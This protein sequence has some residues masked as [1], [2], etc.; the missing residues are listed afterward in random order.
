MWLFN[1][2]SAPKSGQADVSEPIIFRFHQRSRIANALKFLIPINLLLFVSIYYLYAHTSRLSP[3]PDVLP[4][5]QRLSAKDIFIQ[6]ALG[7]EIDGPFNSAPLTAL[8]RQAQWIDGLIIKCAAAI[9]GV[10]NVRNIFLNCV[11][12][13]IEAGGL[14]SLLPPACISVL[15][16]PDQ[17][18]LRLCSLKWPREEKT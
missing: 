13:A 6:K 15:L 1:A 11:R 17:Q 5:Y 3:R 12:Y 14:F 9:G 10:G 7:N 4:Y 16:I 18:Q 8:C 2:E